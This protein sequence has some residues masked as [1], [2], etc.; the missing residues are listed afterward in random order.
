[1]RDGNV[2]CSIANIITIFVVS[3][4]MRDGNVYFIVPW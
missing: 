1:M 2:I 3:L 4:P